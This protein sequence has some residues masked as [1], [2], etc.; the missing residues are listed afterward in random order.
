[1]RRLWINAT[2]CSGCRICQL[3]CSQRWTGDGFNSRM[4]AIQVKVVDLLK[5]DVPVV[6]MQCKRAPCEI[7]CPTGAIR[8]E[9]VTGVLR[10]VEQEC[11]GCGACARACPFGAIILHP[12]RVAPI[13][14]DLCEGKPLCA[15]HCPTGALVLRPEVTIGDEKRQEYATKRYGAGEGRQGS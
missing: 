12:Q 11:I 15:D 9:A 8:R 13:K 14:C 1:M 3:V 10:I 2:K 6:C 5:A 4:S 7:E